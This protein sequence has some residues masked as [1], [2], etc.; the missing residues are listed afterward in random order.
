VTKKPN[1]QEFGRP[2]APCQRNEASGEIVDV[3]PGEA[4]WTLDVLEGLFDF[5]IVQ[6]K[7]LA[8]KKA[9][10]NVKLAG[11]GKPGMK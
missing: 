1:R 8:A 4:E 2:S 5:F 9:A 3:E 7:R 6:P 10:L 11:L